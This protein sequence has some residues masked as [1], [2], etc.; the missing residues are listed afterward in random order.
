M[1]QPSLSRRHFMRGAAALTGAA[2]LAPFASGQAATKR[3]ATDLVTLG[4]TGIKLSR[5]GIGTGVNNGG[6]NMSPGKDAFVKVIRHA[7]DQG[8]TYIDCAQR[9]STFD[10][11]KEG[12][13]GTPREKLYI[14]SKIWPGDYRDVMAEID[15]HRRNFDT[16]YIDSL[17]V[18]CRTEPNWTEQWKAMLDVYDQAKEKKWIRARGVSCHSM[19]ALVQANASPWPDMHLVR[20]NPQGLIMDGPNGGWNAQSVNPVQPVLDQIKSMHD[21]GRGVIGMKIFGNGLIRDPAKREESIRFAMGNP[22]IDAIVIGMTSTKEV[23]EN[24]A[25]MNKVL[26]AA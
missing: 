24:I 23:D 2:M 15:R 3:T 7:I 4:N 5:L 10:V 11:I 9:Y 6:D 8:I 20:I 19:A 14:Q 22:D 21:K 16:D 17:L 1:K 12:I 25:M 26:A 13:K 18:H